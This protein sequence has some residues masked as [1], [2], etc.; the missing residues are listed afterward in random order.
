M[1]ILV[2]EVKLN[3]SDVWGFLQEA[4]GDKEANVKAKG[5]DFML[6]LGELYFMGYNSN[7]DKHTVFP[8]DVHVI[9]AG[10]VL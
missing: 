5:R 4:P 1:D 3:L 7:I 10:K 2:A 8:K 6:V 9:P